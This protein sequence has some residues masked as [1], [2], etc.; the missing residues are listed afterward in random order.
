MG[1]AD[2]V[3]NAVKVADNVTRSLQ[4][5]VTYTPVTGYDA[6]GA[7]VYGVPVAKLAIVEKRQRLIRTTQ[8]NEAMSQAYVAFLQPTTINELDK[9]VLPDGT[10]GPILNWTGF[11]DAGTGQPYYAEVYLGG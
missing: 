10:T 11:V 7:P 3:R 8:S 9:I 1:L 2:V 6:F 4:A 5:T